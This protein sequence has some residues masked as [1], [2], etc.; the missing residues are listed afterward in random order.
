ML[1]IGIVGLPNVGKSSLFKA[2]TKKQV[3]CEN[4]PFCTI[5][6]NVG[7]VFVPDERV[8]KLAVMSNSAKKVYATVEFVD[9]AGLVEGA[10]KGE[11]L[12]NQFLSHI[13]EVDAVLY[14]LRCFNNNNIINTRNE[15]NP[16]KDKEILETEL[17]LKDLAVIEKR[18]IGLDKDVRRGDKQAV[19]EKQVLEKAKA[20]LEKGESLNKQSFTENENLVLNS[21][22]LLTQKPCIFL[23]NG[24]E[25]EI[26]ENVKK[27][28]VEN[29]LCFSIFDILLESEALELT[30]AE[31]QELG[32]KETSGLDVLI[33]QAFKLLNLIVFLTTGEQETRA[34]NLEKESKAPQA[35]G[36]IHTDFEKTFIKADV[37]SWQT[38]LNEGSWGKAREKG[39]V[40]TE[41]KDYIVK[42]G[43]V[44]IIKATA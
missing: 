18:L 19:F 8:D 11:G 40:R 25:E 23:L 35:G 15:I 6:P 26:P 9:I 38:L 41:G 17:A 34:W 4:Y 31:K 2:I 37:I 32:L 22:Q 27:Y 29:N 21:L 28:F 3:A 7:V 43:D 13:R 12:G 1:S 20:F 44:L 24:K 42:D 30:K 39:L 16:L 10:N 14:V 33:K 5:E 36:V